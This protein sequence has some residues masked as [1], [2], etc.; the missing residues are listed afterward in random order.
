VLSPPSWRGSRPG[1]RG[2][3]LVGA[4]ESGVN[5]AHLRVPMVLSCCKK[6]WR[7]PEIV[8]RIEVGLSLSA[9]SSRATVSTV[10]SGMTDDCELL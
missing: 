4:P 8:P 9:L 1:Y 6:F 3:L 2:T 10:N 7:D 5:V